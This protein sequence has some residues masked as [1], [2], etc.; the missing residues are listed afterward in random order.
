MAYSY[1]G[2]GKILSIPR[3]LFTEVV[4]GLGQT[5]LCRLAL[6]CKQL[7]TELEDFRYTDITLRS[8]SAIASFQQA[9]QPQTR[10]SRQRLRTDKVL[11]LQLTWHAGG[12][13]TLGSLSVYDCLYWFCNNL[14]SL[15]TLAIQVNNDIPPEDSVS[16][17]PRLSLLAISPIRRLWISPIWLRKIETIP[18]TLTCLTV[19]TAAH[20]LPTLC[21]Y[22]VRVFADKLRRLRLFRT[23]E[24]GIHN[25]S[26]VRICSILYRQSLE[27]LEVRD[28]VAPVSVLLVPTP[29]A[30]VILLTLF[31][32]SVAR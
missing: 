17:P 9:L 18:P 25:E 19:N 32:T 24:H 20:S 2:N 15:V 23:F 13:A 10:D 5:D 21:I 26:P 22:I 8:A 30:G 12:Q 6:S 4:K 16:M 11:S 29:C 27:Y 31:F 7:A 14:P 1:R 28:N 3:E